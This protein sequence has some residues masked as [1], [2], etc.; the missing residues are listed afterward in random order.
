MRVLL[1]AIPA[2]LLAAALIA[3]SGCADSSD[4]WVGTVERLPNGLVRVTNPAQGVWESGA[5]WR[6]ESELVLG[7]IEG[8]RPDAFGAISAITIDGRGRVHVLDRQ[9]NELRIFEPDGRHVRTVGRS[10]EGRGEYT[11]ANGLAWLADDTL[12]VVDQEGARYTILTPDGDFVR[13]VPRNLGFYGWVFSGAI[14]DGRIYESSGVRRGEERI[15]ALLGT[16]LQTPTRQGEGAVTQPAAEPALPAAGDTIMLPQPDAPL[17]ESFSVRTERAG[18]VIG[19]PFAAGSVY[20]LD[21]TGNLWHGHGSA[22]RIFHSTLAGDT[23]IEIVLEYEPTQVSSDEIA[24]WEAGPGIERFRALGGKIDLGRIP[25]SKPYFD[26]IFT[27]GDGNVWLGVP[28]P[29]LSTAFVVVDADG[30][31]LGRLQI[32]GVERDP[33]LRP[34]ARN[35]RLYFVGKDELDVQRVHVYRVE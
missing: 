19:V 22:P 11:T 32:D 14:V 28:S 2:S 18:M 4:A 1:P 29:P 35:D 10:G 13:T 12:V 5:P 31:Y 17:Y 24:E 27:D 21:R 26:D 7:S 23:L 20:S 3:G 15:P 34:T 6:L 25:K 16:L 30:R 9:A 8:D 33:Y